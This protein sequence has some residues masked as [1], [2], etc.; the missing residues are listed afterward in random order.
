MVAAI[1][2]AAEPSAV[3]IIV[4]PSLLASRRSL[5]SSRRDLKGIGRR[6]P[7]S[8]C[9][10]GF[11]AR[12]VPPPDLGDLLRR[13]PDEEDRRRRLRELPELHARLCEEAVPLAMV[14][15]GAGRDDVL[16]HR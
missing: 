2:I 11:E 14:A 4:L 1:T 13:Q 10:D 15:G 8:G 16:P 6:D 12:Q 3:R 7:A 9:G 5:T